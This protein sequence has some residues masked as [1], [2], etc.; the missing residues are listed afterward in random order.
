MKV[1]VGDKIR[2]YINFGG[3][4]YEQT[5][6]VG[7]IDTWEDPE[8]PVYVEFIDK[9]GDNLGLWIH[10]DPHR[11]KEDCEAS[12]KVLC[13]NVARFEEDENGST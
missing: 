13:K 12:G 8:P 6:E 3:V 11:P 2:A 7:N 1:K 10:N 9:N 4:E 5:V